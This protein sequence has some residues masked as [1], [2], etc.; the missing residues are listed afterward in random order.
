MTTVFDE[1]AGRRVL[2]TGG[3]SGIGEAV[4]RLLAKHGMQ[5]AVHYNTSAD[6]AEAIAEDIRKAG[7]NA[8]TVGA[9][10]RDA[11]VA[12]GVVADAADRLGGLDMLINNAGSLVGRIPLADITDEALDTLLDTNIRSVVACSRAAIPH[13]RQSDAG[14]IVNT[15]SVAARNGGGPGSVVYAATKGFVSTMTRG[16]AK[17]LA[18]DRIRV[19]AVAP[20]VIQTPLH[21]RFTTQEQLAVIAQSIPMGRLGSAD[22]CA[23]AFLW[24]ASPTLSSYV[25]GQIIEVNGGQVMP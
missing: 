6:A 16:L 9:D 20:G 14:S 13:L 1:L 10:I 25:T 11:T 7:G 5:V 8:L 19:N 18:P 17:E 2:V 22:E 4:A 12:A 24:L 23:G 21:D 3:S 15:T